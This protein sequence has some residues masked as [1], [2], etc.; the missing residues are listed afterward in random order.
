MSST[1]HME[2]KGEKNPQTSSNLLTVCMW[3][4]VL[5]SVRL[6]VNPWIVARQ[7]PLSM[8]FSRQE[9]WSRL[10]FPIAGDLPNPGIEAASLAS[11]ALA[12]RFLTTVPPGKPVTD[13]RGVSN[14]YTT[15]RSAPKLSCQSFLEDFASAPESHAVAAF[16]CRQKG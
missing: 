14:P 7:V 3:C 15:P 12:G 16:P 4:A 8:E 11:P 13:Y 1:R 9:Y 5:S 10:P 6:F 2:T